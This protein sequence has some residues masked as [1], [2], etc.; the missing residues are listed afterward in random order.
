MNL[1]NKIE[2]R[3]AQIG[4][5]GLGYV[6]LPLAMEFVRAGFHVTGI[7]VDQEKVKKLNRGENYI[8]DIK[9]ESVKNAVEMNQLSATSDFSVIQNL[10]AISICVP[11]PLNKQKNPDIS[12]INHVMENIKDL[13]HHDM[14]VVLESTTYP[15]TTRELILPE[16]ESKGLKV[17][18]DF[19]LCFS[20]ERI[21]PGNEKYKTANTPKILGGITPNCGEMGEFLYE[22]IVE[23]VVRV[24]SPE[25]AEMVKLLEN[26]FRAIN[27]GLANEVAIMCEKL[28]INVWEVIDAAATKPFGFMKFTPGP[29]LGGHC[30]PID[31]HYLSWKLK[32]LDY[33]ARF[34]ELAGEINT[35]MPLHIVDLVREGLNRK[36]K[37]ISGS[38]ILIIG[39]A[40]KKNVNDARESPA[41][42]VLRLLENDGAELSF[43]DPYVPFVGLNGNR[44]MGME[45]LSKESLNNSDAIVIMTDHDQIDFQ[46]V[47]ENGNLII[48]S[49]NVIKMNHSH[50]I[51]LGVGKKSDSH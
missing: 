14:I 49:R 42:D 10:D 17:G 12:F 48:D 26:T 21:D 37:A 23:Q 43:Y 18:Q 45:T 29:G 6:G 36:R 34:I 32:M 22:T 40:Y 3:D 47:V 20:P 13:I 44:M 4:V 30:I 7:D 2:N 25:T 15:G 27:I 28:G 16:I 35:S 38:Q 31:P 41:L 11:T 5:I 46:F 9:D 39:V 1:K 33:N 50:V 51:K 24:S 8:Q 19:Y